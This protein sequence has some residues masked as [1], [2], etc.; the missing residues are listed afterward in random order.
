MVDTV[1]R[2]D[3]PRAGA[4]FIS[5]TTLPTY[6]ALPRLEERLG[7]PVGS[8]NQITAWA[9]L[10]AVANGSTVLA[11]GSSIELPDVSTTRVWP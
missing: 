2:G 1:I 3:H 6:E 11:S 7:E 9:L 8:A 5:C 10:G 4:V